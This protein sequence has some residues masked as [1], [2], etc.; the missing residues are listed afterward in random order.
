MKNRAMKNKSKILVINQVLSFK[1]ITLV[2][3]WFKILINQIVDLEAEIDKILGN[4]IT[5]AVD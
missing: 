2:L 1:N 4:V 3:C 5:E